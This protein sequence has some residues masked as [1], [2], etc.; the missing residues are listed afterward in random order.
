VAEYIDLH[1]HW[2]V[3][4]D[5]GCV[6]PVESV[7]MLLG[8][9]K[10]GFANVVATPHMRPGLFDNDR[11]GI[12]RAFEDQ[13][14]VLTQNAHPGLPALSIS[15][16]HYFND[17]VYGRIQQ[18]GALPYPGEHAILLEFYENTFPASLAQ[19]LGALH[20]RGLIP[21]IAHPERYRNLWS[22]ETALERLL[23]VGAVALLDIGAVIGKYGTAA[24]KAARRFLEK[25]Y[26]AAACS[27]AHRA[28]D[29]EPVA[30][31]M[32][33]LRKNFGETEVDAL[34][35]DGP[36]TILEGKTKAWTG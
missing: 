30:Q 27:D 21:V 36:R 25:G 35:L 28:K 1:C 34:F 23:D 22:D 24:K 3:G 7:Q 14:S 5:D 16:E 26:Y 11:A 10:L 6:S 4:L 18:H 31:G 20:R 33:W 17:E 19:T 15:A 32:S 13:T 29:L 8:L 12:I 2:L 9:A